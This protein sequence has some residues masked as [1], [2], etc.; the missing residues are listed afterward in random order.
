MA[1]RLVGSQGPLLPRRPRPRHRPCLIIVATVGAVE[2]VVGDL[3]T[4]YW[5]LTRRLIQRQPP[6]DSTPSP[7][8]T[9]KPTMLLKVQ[10]TIASYPLDTLFVTTNENASTIDYLENSDS[11]NKLE[12]VTVGDGR[13]KT[14]KATSVKWIQKNSPSPLTPWSLKVDFVIQID[15]PSQEG[16]KRHQPGLNYCT[17]GR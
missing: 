12:N 2:A 1:K 7:I 9:V 3:V 14:F 15:S 4:L 10:T 6:T 5:S 11:K 16:R 8:L 13:E 17:I